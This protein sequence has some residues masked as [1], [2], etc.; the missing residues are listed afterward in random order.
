MSNTLAPAIFGLLTTVAKR[1][2]KGK[3]LRGFLTSH[4]GHDCAKTATQKELD[5]MEL[6]KHIN[7]LQLL[8]DISP[9]A[10]L[11]SAIQKLK[12][13]NIEQAVQYIEA[14]THIAAQRPAHRRT[15]KAAGG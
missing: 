11:L 14:V 2:P 3:V 10:N 8:H 4:E 5:E 7:L 15:P 13:G 12:T 9:H 6:N 1:M